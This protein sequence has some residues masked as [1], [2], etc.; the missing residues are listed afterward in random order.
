MS[1]KIA[2]NLISVIYLQK[3]SCFMRY[4]Y[5]IYAVLLLSLFLNTACE[6]DTD[7]VASEAPEVPF[8]DSSNYIPLTVGNSWEYL[9]P[10]R[11]KVISHLTDTTE[12]KGE[13]FF[14]FRNL[15][16]DDI[17]IRRYQSQYTVR[18]SE[19]LIEDSR[20]TLKTTAPFSFL[21]LD[22]EH[23]DNQKWKTSITYTVTYVPKVN[24]AAKRPNQR[25]EAEYSGKIISRN[26]TRKI[27]PQIFKDVIQVSIEETL[28]T[29]KTSHTF[30]IAKNIGI[31]EYTK[32]IDNVTLR[33]A[34]IL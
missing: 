30:Y 14:T 20:Y 8:I 3:N 26:G 16:K 34:T 22:Y 25:M 32:G 9:N 1:N 21:F 15:I 18:L 29:K 5:H 19:P 7:F 33:K 6:A 24:G 27:G 12:V 17:Q 10:D 28:G 11:S 31:I 2:F 23:A 4:A 13:R